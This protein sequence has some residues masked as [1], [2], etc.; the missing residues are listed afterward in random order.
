MLIDIHAHI[1]DD[2]LKDDVENVV[3]R[4]SEAG[5]KYIVNATCDIDSINDTLALAKKFENVYATLGIHPQALF[6][7]DEKVENMIYA[8][9]DNPKVIGVGEIGLDYH[10][11]ETQ[12]AYIKQSYPQYQNITEDEVIKVQKDIF[13]KQ[14][15]LASR[16]NLP[17]VVHSRDAT[18]DTL[19]II[20][21]YA[22]ILPQKGL[23]H[24]FSGSAEIAREYFKLGFYISVG[25]SV[26]FKNAR[27]IPEVL[28]QCGIDNVMLE[29]D[30]PYLCPEP[31]RGQINEPKNVVL[32]NDKIADLLDLDY[33]EVEEKTTANARKLFGRL[34]C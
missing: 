18:Q 34:P 4:A 31:Y 20:K 1:D 32:V 27:N 21:K 5:V 29:T 15:K 8:E 28:R 22:A 10:D 24:C 17:I 9:K 26:T 13:I 16:M 2:K 14:I 12:I 23:I 33:K 7:Y 19:E 25:G 30:C 3:K 11:M 6:E